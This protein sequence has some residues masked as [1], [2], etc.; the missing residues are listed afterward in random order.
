MAKYLAVYSNKDYELRVSFE[1][2]LRTTKPVGKDLFSLK[3][4]G[5]N[6]IRNLNLGLPSDLVEDEIDIEWSDYSIGDYS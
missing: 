2:S 5:F 3:R 6:K 1:S 4:E